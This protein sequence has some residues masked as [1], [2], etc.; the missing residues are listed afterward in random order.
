MS[1]YIIV[2]VRG[3]VVQSV[4][5]VPSSLVVVVYDYQ[6]PAA[7]AENTDDAGEPCCKSEWS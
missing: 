1:D 4:E 6:V 7:D 2:R 5:N 3:G